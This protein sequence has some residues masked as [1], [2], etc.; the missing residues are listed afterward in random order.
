MSLSAL[1]R[2]FVP[3][4][5]R[6]RTIHSSVVTL[7]PRRTSPRAGQFSGEE[8]IV[9]EDDLEDQFL[10]DDTTS[11]GHNLLAQHRQIL[12]YMRAI[13]HEMPQ[14]VAYRKP[15]VP[16]GPSSPLAVRSIYYGGEEHPATEKRTIVAAVAK[17]PLANDAAIHKFKLLA[18]PR[19]T[20][21]PP[22]DAG[23]GM[24]EG[25]QEHGYFK[26]SCEDFPKGAMNLKW[27][28]DTLDKLLKEANDAKDTFSDIP[29]DTRHVDAK[30]RK[31]KKGEHARSRG[32]KRP[33][34]KDFPPEWLPDSQPEPQG[35]PIL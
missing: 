29:L 1:F 4:M 8:D 27:A 22:R 7:M 13:E 35:T 26:I 21:D 17:L 30:A 15:F 3:S 23:L 33:S 9:T 34:I 25:G 11:A 16:P 10:H 19:W 28:S 5:T 31:A 18:G 20:P 24:D 6:Q 14:L 12:H 32:A 2:T